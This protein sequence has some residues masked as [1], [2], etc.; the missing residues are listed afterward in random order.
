MRKTIVIVENE[1]RVRDYLVDVMSWECPN[2]I[3]AATSEDAEPDC[4]AKALIDE[5]KNTLAFIILDIELRG[6]TRF[7]MATLEWIRQISELSDLPVLVLTKMQ[8]YRGS[9][10]DKDYRPLG[11]IQKPS[12]ESWP[13]KK[14]RWP[15][16]RQGDTA[17]LSVEELRLEEE[18]GIIG[19]CACRI[20]HL[21]D[22]LAEA[23]ASD[24]NS[25]QRISFRVRR[26]IEVDG[27]VQ[28]RVVRNVLMTVA[29]LAA[30]VVT[31][32]GIVYSLGW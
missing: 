26:K 4:G 31:I 10:W 22:L 25:K 16:R 27:S 30:A 1:P 18:L 13:P 24:S 6:G 14:D 32:M 11:V 12:V 9:Q 2:C 5:H 21:E 8:G 29:I 23:V 28:S 15:G 3:V 7:G 20:M 19:R 17:G